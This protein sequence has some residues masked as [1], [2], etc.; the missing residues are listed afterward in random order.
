MQSPFPGIVP[1]L[2]DPGDWG[3]VYDALVALWC[4]QLKLW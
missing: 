2:G 1:Y 4:A 3:G